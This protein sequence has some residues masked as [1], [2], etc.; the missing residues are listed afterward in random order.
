MD[1]FRGYYSVLWFGSRTSRLRWLWAA[2]MK[3]R[4]SF[5]LFAAHEKCRNVLPT[6]GDSVLLCYDFRLSRYNGGIVWGSVKHKFGEIR[7][8]FRVWVKGNTWPPDPRVST[9][10]QCKPARH[11]VKSA[12]SI[13]ICTWNRHRHRHAGHALQIVQDLQKRHAF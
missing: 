3:K 4:P 8:F 11:M 6:H 9:G 5:K 1:I 2:S 7:S 12:D 10:R 13:K